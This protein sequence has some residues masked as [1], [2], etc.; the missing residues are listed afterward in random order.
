MLRTTS[1]VILA[2]TLLAPTMAAAEAATATDGMCGELAQM[3]EWTPPMASHSAA[4]FGAMRNVH[5]GQSIAPAPVD[6]RPGLSMWT[7]PQSNAVAL[8]EAP[9]EIEDILWC[10]S[11]DDPRCSP[12]EDSK[13]GSRLTVRDSASGGLSHQVAP[14]FQT[15]LRFRAAA[16]G[17][18]RTAH[19]LLLERPPQS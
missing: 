7:A 12:I 4:S 5:A 17:G 19:G 8:R 16:G 10:A 15:T 13:G 3:V 6:A 1:S 2:V 9:L 14:A 11:P 18:P